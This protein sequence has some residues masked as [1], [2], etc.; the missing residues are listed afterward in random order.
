A[1]IDK[2]TLSVAKPKKPLPG[3]KRKHPFVASNSR[4]DVLFVWS[5]GTAWAKGGSVAWQLFSAESALSAELG[6]A[7]GLPMWSLPTAFA[8]P[9]GNFVVLY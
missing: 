7:D 1:S 8:T 4:G 6:R 3:G 5:E 9:D 2:Q